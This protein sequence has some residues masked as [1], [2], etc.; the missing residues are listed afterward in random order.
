MAL[1][2]VAELPGLVQ[3]DEDEGSLPQ[4]RANPGERLREKIE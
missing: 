3:D 4:G 1:D 2:E